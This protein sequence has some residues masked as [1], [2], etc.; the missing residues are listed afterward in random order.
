MT[1]RRLLAVLGFIFALIGG[2]LLLLKA[3]DLPKN[4]TFESLAR[5]GIAVV[6]GIA[7][8]LGGLFIH[9]GRMSAGGFLTVLI[10]VLVIVLGPGF[11]LEAVLIIVA[12]I[13]GIVGAEMRA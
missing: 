1:E 9:R 12:G 11:G 4:L 13:L 6:L 3:F 2:L 8:I 10:G 5:L 7:A